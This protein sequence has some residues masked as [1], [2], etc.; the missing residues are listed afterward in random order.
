MSVQ[1]AD[2]MG[3][4]LAVSSYIG[5]AP[6]D[7]PDYIIA[8]LLEK[9]ISIDESD[10]I[11][12]P[13]TYAN[14]VLSQILTYKNI[15]ADYFI[16]DDEVEDVTDEAVQVPDVRGKDMEE[17]RDILHELGLQTDVYGKDEVSSQFPEGGTDVTDDNP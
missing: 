12:S 14:K 6:V 15:P 2:E 9:E 17:A 5:F 11:E 8:I 16:T 13:T 7:D 1:P 10:S 4:A 3:N